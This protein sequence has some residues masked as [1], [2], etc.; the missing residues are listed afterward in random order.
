MV[1]ADGCFDPLHWGHVR[2]L[3][4]C[5]VFGEL[6]VR[7]GSDADVLKKGRFLFQTR[8]E[9]LKTVGALRCVSAVLMEDMALST[10]VRELVPEYLIK[11][12][13]WRGKLPADVVDACADTGTQIIYVETQERTSTERL[14]G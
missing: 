9:R 3:S 4:A 6:T 13:D 1:L 14:A 10:A 5:A 2:Y 8:E 11:G 7:V 12:V